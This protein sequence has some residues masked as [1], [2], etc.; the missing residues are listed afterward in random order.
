MYSCP[1][2]HL[3]MPVD[4]GAV[5]GRFQPFHLGHL[6]YVL[7]AHKRCRSLVIGIRNPDPFSAVSHPLDVRKSGPSAN[8]FTFYE[9]MLMIEQS[10]SARR[11]PKDSFHI[12]PFPMGAPWRTKYYVPKSAVL[13]AATFEDW[14][15][16]KTTILRRQGYRVFVFRTGGLHDRPVSGSDIRRR[17]REGRPWEYLVPAPVARVIRATSVYRRIW[18]SSLKD[19]S[20]RTFPSSSW[21]DSP[22]GSK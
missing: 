16:A 5:S 11:I 10:L 15:E 20:P 19:R 22:F 17:M 1:I 21:P 4:L 14:S 12:V 3:V 9:R 18:R 7:E 6:E 8:P 13:F 2:S